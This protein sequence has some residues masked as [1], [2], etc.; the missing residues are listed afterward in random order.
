MTPTDLF[1]SSPLVDDELTLLLSHTHAA[2]PRENDA[3]TYRFQCSTARMALASATSRCV[4]P[5]ANI[6]CNTSA[7][8]AMVCTRSSAATATPPAPAA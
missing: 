7:I 2:G 3:L 1:A 4:L 8:S 6:S 5:T